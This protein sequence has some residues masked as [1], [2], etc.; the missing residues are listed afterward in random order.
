MQFFVGKLNLSSD[1][2]LPDFQ[3]PDRTGSAQNLPDTGP[4]P[5]GYPVGS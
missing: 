4:D 2:I 3:Q 5:T 1:P